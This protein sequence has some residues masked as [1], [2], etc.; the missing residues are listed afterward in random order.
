MIPSSSHGMKKGET[1][2]IECKAWNPEG[3]LALHLIYHFETF[4]D[5]MTE[6]EELVGTKRHAPFLI[7]MEARAIEKNFVRNAEAA[8]WTAEIEVTGGPLPGKFDGEDEPWD[9][10][11][12]TRS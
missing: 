7:G 9:P 6:V 11:E 8:G 2:T 5:R 1:Q 12:Y 10:S 3:E 4:S